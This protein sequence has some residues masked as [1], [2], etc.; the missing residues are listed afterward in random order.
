VAARSED[1]GAAPSLPPA[2]AQAQAVAA[3]SP[4]ASNAPLLEVSS[5]SFR[6]TGLGAS[7]ATERFF[8]HLLAPRTLAAAA[9]RARSRHTRF[10]YAHVHLLHAPRL[11]RLR[12]CADGCPLPGAPVVLND[13]TFSVPRGACC[14]LLGSN[15][16]GKTT[17]LKLLAGKSMVPEGAISVLG[18]NAFHDTDLTCGG[19]LAYIGGQWQKDVAFAGAG[20]PLQGDFAAGRMLDSVP[21]DPE[22]KARIIRALDVDVNWRM[23]TVSDG[24]RRRVQLAFGLLRPFSLL[25]LDEVTVDLDV[26]ARAELM[27]FLKAECEERNVSVIYASHIMDGLSNWATHLALLAG[28]KLRMALVGEVSEL[29]SFNGRLFPFVE[30]WLRED[31][32]PAAARAAAEPRVKAAAPAQ[33]MNNGWGSGR[34]TATVK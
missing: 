28:G 31:Q 11:T 16:A 3:P 26:L 25:L 10:V 20:V 6:H 22:R 23:H 34:N 21:C 7:H 8:V 5:L 19:A 13:V 27:T 15:G 17:L 33:L 1:S 9:A 4:E 24:Q 14:L 2:V 12:C 32:R 30:A 29:A 18:R